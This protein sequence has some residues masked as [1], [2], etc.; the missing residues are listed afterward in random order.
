MAFAT[1]HRAIVGTLISTLSL[2][3]CSQS[4]Q[5]PEQKTNL[6]GSEPLSTIVPNTTNKPSKSVAITAIVEHPSLDAIRQGVIDELAAEGYQQGSNLKVNFQSAQGSTATVGQISKQF[7]ADRPD[8]IVAISTPSAQSIAVATKD[9]PIVYTAVSDPVTAKL[10]DSK[11]RPIQANIT[12]LSTQLPLGPQLDMIQQL[13][14]NAKTLGY[15]YSPGEM[16]SVSVRDNLKAD[17]P[18][19]GMTLIEMPANRPTDIAMAT[20]SLEGKAQL[21]YTSMDNNVASAFESMVKTA[22]TAKLPIIAS[23]EFS[24][25]RGATA[26]LGVNDYEFGRTTG[27]MV[28]QILDGK[29]VT[30]VPPQIMNK[31]TLFVSPKHAA[32]QGVTIPD[33]LL[34]NAINVDTTPAKSAK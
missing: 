16:N 7:V 18:K 23:D 26:A 34:R 28:A 21:I 11:N 14:P 24:V 1:L 19:R 3:G 27:K 12:G 4:E 9:I 22:N 10:I 5:R 8:A 31:L 32:L 29:P 15:V 6:T 25:R 13:I 17:L 33:S 30:Q 20:N 2:A